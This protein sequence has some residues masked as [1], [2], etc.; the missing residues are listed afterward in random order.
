[1]SKKARFFLFGVMDYSFQALFD[2]IRFLARFVPPRVLVATAYGIGYVMYYIRMESRQWLLDALREALPEI[3]DE[4]QLKKIARKVFSAPL[5]S[6]LDP[7]FLERYSERVEETLRKTTDVDEIARKVRETEAGGKGLIFFSPHLGGISIVHAISARFGNPY[8]PLVRHPDYTP[9]PRYV[10]KLALL[11]QSLGCDPEEPAF[12]TGPGSNVV[13]KV[14]EHLKKGKR[15]GITFDMMGST[16]VDFFGRPTAIASG[17]AL[18]ALESGAPILP[19]YLARGKDPLT[20]RLYLC[21]PLQYEITG[22]RE[23]DMRNI[24][25]KVIEKG[26]EMIRKAP[27][28]WIS[29]FGL[30]QWRERA[31]KILEEKSPSDG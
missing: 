24:L 7:I 12:F 1:V 6:M 16:V 28:D 25:N 13:P 9:V 22:D 30:R 2:F 26:E 21:E 8:T 31:K 20:Y 23:A 29:W 18:F 11:A 10:W 4:R 3:S 5:R 14:L 15:V 19:G 27:E 17:I